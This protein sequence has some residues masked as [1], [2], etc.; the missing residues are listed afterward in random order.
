[1]AHHEFVGGSVVDSNDRLASE[2]RRICAESD[3]RGLTLRLC[4]GV[5]FYLH[6]GDPSRFERLGR[7]P[8]QDLDFVG[9]SEERTKYKQLFKDLGYEIDQDMLVAAEGRR[10]LFR[11][12]GEESVEVDVFI[13]RLAMCHT[14]QLRERLALQPQTVPLVDL[15]LQKLQI[16]DLTRKDTVDVVV[17]LADHDLGTGSPD[18]VDA[19]HAAAL[20][21]DDWGFYYT[22]MSNVHN[23]REFAANAPLETDVR[24]VVIDRLARFAQALESADK[25]RKWKLRAKVGT[26]KKWYDDVEEDIAAF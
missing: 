20:L 11:R 22:A 16:V 25:T 9:L 17:L 13:D 5:G 7:G 1:M 23:I 4:G 3:R 14:L 26:R 21:R 19:A 24:D 2:A 18:V 12:T 15:M 10:F 6:A 8:F